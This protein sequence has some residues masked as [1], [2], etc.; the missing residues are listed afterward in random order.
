VVERVPAGLLDWL[1]WPCRRIRLRATELDGRLVIDGV[2]IMKGDQL[3]AARYEADFEQMVAY[4]RVADAKPPQS[5]LPPIGFERDRVVWRDSGA[6]LQSV[7]PSGKQRGHR[8]P[9]SLSAIADRRLGDHSSGGAR[10]PIELFGVNLDQF[11]ALFWRHERLPVP[12]A[13]LNDQALYEGLERALRLVEDSGRTLNAATRRLA[14]LL[15]SRDENRRPDPK[16][17]SALAERMAPGRRY[18]AQLGDHF[19][20]FLGAQLTDREAALTTWA[21]Q[22]RDAARTAFSE[23]AAGQGEQGWSLR[24]RVEAERTLSMGLAGA[25][26]RHVG[27]V[28]EET[29]A[30]T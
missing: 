18:W 27:E 9:R 21:N 30:T 10:M 5:P 6:L 8:R 4:R 24:A 22:V 28:Q 3:P 12:T 15:L 20:Q 2:L 25:R 16:A 17:V 23:V 13:Y 29:S 26:K 14:E 11:N 19:T 1:T 7:P